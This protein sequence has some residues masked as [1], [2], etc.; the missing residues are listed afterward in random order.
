MW[1]YTIRWVVEKKACFMVIHQE[2]SWLGIG[3]VFKIKM[4]PSHNPL[5][6]QIVGMD[7]EQYVYSLDETRDHYS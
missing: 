6:A 5:W 3:F 7:R 1:L 2:A 4:N